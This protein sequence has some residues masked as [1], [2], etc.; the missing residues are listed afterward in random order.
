[1]S[2]LAPQFW[3]YIPAL[4]F[5]LTPAFVLLG[6][7]VAEAVG[8]TTWFDANAMR[9]M[10]IPALLVAGWAFL[11]AARLGRGSSWILVAG[12]FAGAWIA[13][14][15]PGQTGSG[16]LALTL[17]GWAIWLFAAI[18]VTADA[19]ENVRWMRWVALPLLTIGAGL[20]ALWLGHEL[21]F[22]YAPMIANG[23]PPV[24]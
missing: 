15:A 24:G 4:S 8:R 17:A 7:W 20:C 13:F 9:N 18:A 16:A 19:V 21:I 10:A 22:V 5:A 2:A 3:R 23:G 6:Q 14:L 11:Q 1:M 12:A